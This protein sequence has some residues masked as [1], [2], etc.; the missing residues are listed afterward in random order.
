MPLA[1]AG[2]AA[3]PGLIWQMASI[4]AGALTLHVGLLAASWSGPYASAAGDG[5]IK[6]ADRRWDGGGGDV[7]LRVASGQIAFAI[8]R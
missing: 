1:C 7:A 3:G 2:M 8:R 6:G 5:A 4:R